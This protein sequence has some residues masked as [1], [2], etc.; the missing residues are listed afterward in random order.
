MKKALKVIAVV[1]GVSVIGFIVVALLFIKALPSPWEIK[2]KLSPQKA[3]SPEFAQTHQENAAA[4]PAPTTPSA[5]VS[6]TH[7]EKVDDKKVQGW[8][9]IKEDFLNTQVPFAS[10][11]TNL[12]MAERSHFLR[13]DDSGSANEF[14]NRLLDTN[15]KDPIVESAASL[16]RYL[17]RLGSFDELFD[18]IEKAERENDQGLLKKAEFYTKLGLAAQEVRSNKANIDRV[19]MKGYNLYV[20]SRA[21]GKHP[22]LARD[23]ATL[24]YCDQLEKNMN[25]N[26]EFNADE[27]AAELQKFLD[28]AKVDPK[29]VGFDPSY[30]SDVKFNFSQNSLQLNHIWIEKL[31]EK[32]IQRAREELKKAP[33]QVPETSGS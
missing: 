8:K 28:Y 33:S 21:V 22:E 19:L 10:V 6:K 5:A 2:Q 14:T 18:M 1:L 15:S 9:I 25:L 16:F 29:E 30:R 20:L 12:P 27:Q 11:C 4:T 3:K 23:P 31:F 7:E 32:D 17:F 24:N 13:A 26:L